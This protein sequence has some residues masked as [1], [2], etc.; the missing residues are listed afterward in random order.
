MLKKN[1]RYTDWFGE[2]REEDFYF[3]LT[4]SELVEMEMSQDGGM[5]NYL[6]K[7]V[8]SKDRNELFQYFK[9]IIL[10]AYGEKSA[11]GRRFMKGEEI[12]RGFEECPAYDELMMQLLNDAEYAGQFVT[13]L[14]PAD[15]QQTIAEQNRQ[16][17][18]PH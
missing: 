6:N 7:I 14:M 16:N 10:K 3:N 11:D 15:L 17:V 9:A 4:K 8:Q 5:E 2:E 13:A 12:S 1:I 18:A